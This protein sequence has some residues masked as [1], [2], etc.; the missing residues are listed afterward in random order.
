MKLKTDK[1]V[2]KKKLFGTY[3]AFYKADTLHKFADNIQFIVYRGDIATMMDK[4]IVIQP[5]MKEQ[6]LE[7]EYIEKANKLVIDTTY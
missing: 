4:N 7:V 2:L 5:M 1:I 6:P 3:T